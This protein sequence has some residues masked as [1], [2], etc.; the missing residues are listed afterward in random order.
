[1]SDQPYSPKIE[2]FLI[3]VLACLFGLT[4]VSYYL[5]ANGKINNFPNYLNFLAL[6]AFAILIPRRFFLVL[7][8]N[9]S[10]VWGWL[11]GFLVYLTLSGL[12]SENGGMPVSSLYLGYSLLLL[13][14]IISFVLC[15]QQLPL[16][17]SWCLPVLILAASVSATYSI[18]FYYG[19]AD[20]HPLDEDRLY[21]LG[22][23]KNPVI[24]AFSYATAL[25]FALFYFAHGKELLE[26]LLWGGCL[27]ILTW[28]L[29]LSGTRAVWV[30]IG[31]LLLASAIFVPAWTR[32]TA[33]I[34]AV[35]LL[36]VL[37]TAIVY[38]Q[39][40]TGDTLLGPR[41]LSF[42]PEIWAASLSKVWQTNPILGLGINSNSELPYGRY[43]FQHSHSIY[44]S[45]LFY[46]GLT[47]LVLLAG[48]LVS[49]L[50]LAFR[51]PDSQEKQ[52]SL[53]TFVFSI[54]AFAVDG[55]RLLEKIDFHWIAFWLPVALIIAISHQQPSGKT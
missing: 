11:I 5:A 9:W 12:W 7:K 39:A 3:P 48:L 40:A 25:V 4:L 24:G 52:M 30:G 50:R 15:Y 18:Y 28:A 14:F 32:K 20:Y 36:P 51:Q 2:R 47:A 54:F 44:F 23:L 27:L 38:F 16:F 55:D 29:W 10:P 42:R 34:I 1:M 49:C 41:Q 8:T 17:K 35:L 22:R 19:L 26:R 6:L 13:T 37:T 31:S 33:T 45:T 43:V 21:A 46:G 53:G